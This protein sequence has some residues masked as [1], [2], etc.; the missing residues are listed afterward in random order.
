M[1]LGHHLA[2][3]ANAVYTSPFDECI[4]MVIDG[5]GENTSMSVYHFADNKFKPLNLI[6]DTHSLGLLYAFVTRLCGFNGWEGEEWKVMGLAPYGSPN[7]DIY[8]FFNDNIKVEGL[9]V[10]VKIDGKSVSSE[11]EP[12]VGGFRQIGTADVMHSAD[13]A[14]N[15]QKWFEETVIKM[16]Q[17]LSELGLSKNLAYGGG[18]A[19]NSSVNGK[20]LNNTGFEQ[21][22]IPSAPAD[23]GNSLGA[24]LHEKYCVR[25]EKRDNKIMSPYLGSNIDI[26]QLEK[27]LDF[28][29]TK[30]RKIS[31]DSA[32][33]SE[34]ADIIAAG[35]IIGWMQGRAEFGPRALGNRS[36]LADPRPADMKDRINK[37]IKFRESFRPFAPS[38]LHEFGNEY[39]EDYQESPY[40]ERTLV[41]RKDVCDRIPAVVHRNGTGR[42]QTVKEEWNPL[43]YCL[44]HNFYKKTGIPVLLN[45]S[46]NIM[47]KPIIHSVEDAITVFYTTGM[48]YLVIG[49]Y[50]LYK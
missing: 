11:L 23:D 25:G 36:V 50:I 12:A 3:A 4:S 32:L 45:T 37:T 44:I 7:P 30:F 31:D 1:G 16:L 38:V 15:F 41:F 10:Q 42:I 20:I 6:K 22:H 2:H 28:K 24:A 40:M 48:D 49:N 47:G 29:G 19:L 14:Y 27:I 43:Y 17:D 26:K 21:L 18:C 39:F 34:V 35:N 33:C 9:N 8:N 5:Y 46:F 13:L